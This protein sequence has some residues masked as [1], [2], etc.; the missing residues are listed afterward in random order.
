MECRF[1]GDFAENEKERLEHAARRYERARETTSSLAPKWAF[2]HF[3]TPYK[4]SLYWG[5]RTEDGYMVKARTASGLAVAVDTA[6]EE[7]VRRHNQAIRQ[8][9]RSVSRSM[10]SQEAAAR[11][12]ASS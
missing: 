12:H 3:N 8:A 6:R 11:E 10:Q 4:G 2:V 7:K 1:R 9:S 5:V